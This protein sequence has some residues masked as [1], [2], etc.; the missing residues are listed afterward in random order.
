MGKNTQNKTKAIV[1]SIRIRLEASQIKELAKQFNCTT[2]MVRNACRYISLTEFS[3]KV[4]QG[5]KE[6]LLKEA[7]KIQ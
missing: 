5:A 4:R 1:K 3:D 2:Q 6:L 7:N